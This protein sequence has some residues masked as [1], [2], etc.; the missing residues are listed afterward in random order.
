MNLAKA[1]LICIISLPFAS[2]TSDYR[3][4]KSKEGMQSKQFHKSLGTNEHKQEKTTNLYDI[5]W[6]EVWNEAKNGEQDAKFKILTSVL[7]LPHVERLTMSPERN[8]LASQSYHALVLLVHNCNFREGDALSEIYRDIA[9]D[10]FMQRNLMTSAK[11][12]RFLKSFKQNEPDC[13]HYAV[14]D[15]LVPSFDQ[16]SSEID[17]LMHIQFKK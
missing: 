6:S 2:C 5:K 8:D 16:Y 7:P 1:L 17:S 3:E 9:N 4:L 14:E 10:F 15:G 13:A 12:N 11:A